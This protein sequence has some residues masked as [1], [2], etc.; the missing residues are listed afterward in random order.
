MVSE[1]YPGARSVDTFKRDRRGNVAM[2]W[3]LMGTV[4]VTG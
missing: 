3:G 2:M 1:R 4:L